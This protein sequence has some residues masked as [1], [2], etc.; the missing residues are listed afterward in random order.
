MPMLAS[1]GKSTLPALQSYIPLESDTP[2]GQELL[3]VLS[4]CN[5]GY[6]TLA[7]LLSVLLD[8]QWNL[9]Y[10]SDALSVRGR[11]ALRA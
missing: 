9:G 8:R 3:N 5:D 1:H 6:L 11:G 10:V 7:L 2:T 4:A